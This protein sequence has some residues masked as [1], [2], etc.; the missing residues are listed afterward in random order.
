MPEEWSI[1]IMRARN[2]FVVTY[3]QEDS[4]GVTMKLSEVIAEKEGCDLAEMQAH[5]GC[6]IAR[7]VV[8]HFGLG[9]SKHDKFRVIIEV[10]E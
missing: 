4:E 1:R 8:E 7:Y 3:Y 5:L 10:E 2:G 9:G 6:D